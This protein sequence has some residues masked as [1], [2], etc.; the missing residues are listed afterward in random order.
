[1]EL[2]FAKELY[3]KS[4]LLKAAYAFLDRAYLHLDSDER[5]FIVRIESKEGH[6]PLLPK[7]FENELL[8]QAVRHE[9]YLETK[10][11][12]EMLVAR[13]IASSVIE[14][15]SE[16]GVTPSGEDF[17]ESDILRNWFDRCN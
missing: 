9:V 16:E 6:D 11:I 14:V 4:V 1:M 12:R 7:E 17:T 13:A 8:V 5:D 3:N 15:P 2:H 10:N